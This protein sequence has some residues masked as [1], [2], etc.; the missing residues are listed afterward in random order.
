ME[1]RFL[2]HS[3]F[4]KAIRHAL[5]ALGFTFFTEEPFLADTLSVVNYPQGIDDKAFRTLYYENGVV[6]AGGLGETAGKLFRMGHMGNLSVSQIYFALDALERTLSALDYK[7][8]TGA[9]LK[10]AR[11]ILGE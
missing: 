1:R 9:S 2:R 3:R 5:A 4:A 10:A 7:F 6:V 8:E 11:A